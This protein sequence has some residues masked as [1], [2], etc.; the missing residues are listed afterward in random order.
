[1][2]DEEVTLVMFFDIPYYIE[3]LWKITVLYKSVVKKLT[4]MGINMV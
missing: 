2:I 3:N 4:N 1:M